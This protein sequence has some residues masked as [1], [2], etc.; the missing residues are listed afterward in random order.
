[1]LKTCL[2][3][4]AGLTA[5][6]ALAADPPSAPNADLPAS[7]PAAGTADTIDRL[8]LE[9]DMQTLPW[10]KFKAVVEAVPKMKASVDAYGPFG[11]QYV[12]KNY[13]SYGWKKNIDRLDDEQRQQLF[14][15]VQRAKHGK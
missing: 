10:P 5:G 15:L 9:H 7:R 4:L 11:W 13:R 14:Q 2:F 3:L 8:Q 6:A 12:E 1:M